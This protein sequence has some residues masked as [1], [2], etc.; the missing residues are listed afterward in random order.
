MKPTRTMK[1]GLIASLVLNAALSLFVLHLSEKFYK[2][3]GN[4]SF[5]IY[6]LEEKLQ[7]S[8]WRRFEEPLRLVIT[9]RR[10]NEWYAMFTRGYND[11]DYVFIS[12]L[13]NDLDEL[14]Y[15]VRTTVD[16]GIPLWWTMKTYFRESTMGTNLT[17]K[18][19]RDGSRDGGRFGKNSSHGNL[20]K[21]ND[22]EY[23][24]ES[25]VRYWKK[26]IAWRPPDEWT[27]RYTFGQARAA[28]LKL[29]HSEAE[30]KI[31]RYST[32]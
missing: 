4:L 30:K 21:L 27:V 19:N 24:V 16:S 26:H 5:K 8:E 2:E 28:K 12:N 14:K 29:I 22:L 3:N 7:Y 13:N 25:F 23:D 10:G 1:I 32:K 17:H 11:T 18:K 20:S 31:G 9:E 6:V 15:I